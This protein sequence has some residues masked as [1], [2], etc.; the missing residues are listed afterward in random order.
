[1]DD[2]SSEI[3]KVLADSSDRIMA[4]LQQDANAAYVCSFDGAP[5][6]WE[7]SEAVGIIQWRQEHVG[8]L[9]RT[10]AWLVG[11][12][13][14]DGGFSPQPDISVRDSCTESTA[15]VLFSLYPATE[16][17][18]RPSDWAS[19]VVKAVNWL[20]DNQD[21]G[22]GWGAMN[23]LEPRVFPTSSAI[24]ALQLTIPIVGAVEDV[25]R[26]QQAIERGLT[27]LGDSV[28]EDGGIGTSANSES[29]VASSS[30]AV[31]AF[32]R[33]TSN[34]P[35]G[36]VKYLQNSLSSNLPGDV[37]DH[38]G[39]PASRVGGRYHFRSLGAPLGLLGLLASRTDLT[40]PIVS[41]LLEAILKSRDDGV[42]VI[43]DG[44]YVWPTYFNV[45]ALRTWL[46]IYNSYTRNLTVA[47]DEL[48][49]L[50]PETAFGHRD[51][52]EGRT[53]KLRIF[54]SHRGTNKNLARKLA[55]I[56]AEIGIDPW[57]DE[58][59]M[60][61]GDDLIAKIRSGIKNSDAAVFLVSADF[62]DS[63][64]LRK[65]V[66][67]AERHQ[68]DNR[69]FRLI[70]IRLMKAEVPENFEHLLWAEAD[71]SSDA[72]LQVIRAIES[73]RSDM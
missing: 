22:G 25:A 48:S 27:W 44:R 37:D 41:K 57:L 58:D 29:T 42:W 13:R 38:I 60:N 19:C 16:L 70:P 18:G 9:D 47:F 50:H 39:H 31:L 73:L 28:N 26:S 14:T 8:L 2:I 61:A 30:H 6:V 63:G 23:G 59:K 7:T 4:L 21:S 33:A 46:S 72:I 3:E 55:R 36:L 71:D 52:E 12:Q 17:F 67:I 68:I 65:E 66:E 51:V 15:R 64:W 40:D 35:L 10:V 54:V 11:Q 53:K 20:L 43:E 1:M 62:I 49:T 5:G 69:R 32:A 34:V 56:L 45:H 24:Q